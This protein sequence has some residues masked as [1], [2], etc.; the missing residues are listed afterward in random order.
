MRDKDQ[1]LLAE[2]YQKVLLREN[3]DPYYKGYP[4]AV[5]DGIMDKTFD[6]YDRGYVTSNVDNPNFYG[7]ELV[8]DQLYL[9]KGID[10]QQEVSYAERN[11]YGDETNSEESLVGILIP[12]ST[13]GLANRV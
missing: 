5:I 10:N 8:K 7:V 11:P 9:I 2:A 12:V 1:Q 6:D 3:G 4:E 13:P